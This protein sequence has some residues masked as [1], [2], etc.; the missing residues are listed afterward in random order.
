MTKNYTNCF[1]EINIYKKMSTKSE[2]ISQMI[3]GESFKILQKK[4]KW[5]KIKVKELYKVNNQWYNNY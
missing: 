5:L 4:K 2:I 3:Y 1:R